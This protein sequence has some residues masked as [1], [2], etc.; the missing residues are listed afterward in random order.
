VSLAR[1]SQEDVRILR[2]E[3]PSVA[4][5]MCKLV[6]LDRSPAAAPLTV[7]SLRRQVAGRIGRAPRLAQ[8]LAPTPLGLANPVWVDD[9]DFDVANHVR[10]VPTGGPVDRERL[11]EIAAGLIEQRLD[12]SRPLWSIELVEEVEGDRTALIWRIHH[13]MADGLTAFRLGSAA[14]WATDSGPAPEQDWYPRP[15]PD[16][17]RLTALGAADR[18]RSLSH[19]ARSTISI[20]TSPRRLM[21]AAI[22]ATR[23]PAA[24]VRELRPGGSESTLD[25][26]PGA[27]RVVAT[28]AVPLADLKRIEH[29]LREPVT[30]N[31]LVLTAV[32]G[33]LRRWLEHAGE[34]LEG[35]RA[36]VPASLHQQDTN[37]DAL[38]NHDSFMF[39][40]LA[41]G[42]RDPIDRIRQINRQTRIRKLHR[43]PEV[44][45]D[46]FRDLRATPGP[47]EGIAS[48][49]AMSPRVFALN[50]SNCPGPAEPLFVGGHRVSELYSFAEIA[51]RHAL[52]VAV[53]SVSGT[54]FFGLCAD[55]SLAQ[56]LS[57]LAEGVEDELSSLSAAAGQLA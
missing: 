24:L 33:G 43:D 4:G 15:A 44:I 21:G 10:S 8:K 46:F 52:R 45:Y 35:V 29:A 13:C 22:E 17:L 23:M 50:I 55:G 11:L 28:A 39:V 12:R 47:L 51:D 5:H 7:G 6:I 27:H 41:V 53:V 9:P 26:H 19:E 18:L 34:S 3:S 16:A 36:K 54:V 31:D 38:G 30:V 1:L 25:R 40:D 49:W 20:L 14:I 42:A 37:A 48:R 32:A 2:L 57:V 56:D